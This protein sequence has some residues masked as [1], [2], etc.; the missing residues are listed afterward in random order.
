MLSV[1]L[2][3]SIDQRERHD[4][5]AWARSRR[6]PAPW[7]CPGERAGAH[8]QDA[9]GQDLGD[10][11]EP[12]GGGHQVEVEGLAHA[13]DEDVGLETIDRDKI[14]PPAGKLQQKKSS[15]EYSLIPTHERSS[16]KIAAVVLH[17]LVGRYF[18]VGRRAN[19]IP[20][21]GVAR[22]FAIA[23][24]AGMRYRR[25]ARSAFQA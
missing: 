6:E 3:V 15:I 1:M 13:G 16:R 24:E 22:G 5:F 2:S 8:A 9:G 23:R 10:L 25:S 18:W 21:P 12:L 7:C 4:R 14:A 20:S 19:G 11:V 17:A